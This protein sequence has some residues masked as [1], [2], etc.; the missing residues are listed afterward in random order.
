MKNSS[1]CRILSI[2]ILFIVFSKSALTADFVV[3]ESNDSRFHPGALIPGQSN[4]VLSEGIVIKILGEDGSIKILKGEYAG[5]IESVDEGIL[6]NGDNGN[7]KL[8]NTVI[9]LLSNDKKSKSTLGAV[10][11]TAIKNKLGLWDI[12]VYKSGIYCILKG[13]KPK[14]VRENPHAAIKVKIKQRGGKKVN[15][16]WQKGNPKIDWPQEIQPISGA[17][18][19]VKIDGQPLP[20]K[21]KLHIIESERA[22]AAA[23]PLLVE[24]KCNSQAK[25]LL[26]HLV[27]S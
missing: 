26:A 12:P 25:R 8:I 4:I 3:V 23:I 14:L 20:V 19:S 27:N 24:K 6:E 7:N 10:R 13:S 11:S 21:I 5:N 1:W 17:T 16:T 2:F 9:K 15:I 22:E 18:F